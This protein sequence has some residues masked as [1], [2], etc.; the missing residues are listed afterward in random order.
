LMDITS[1]PQLLIP[2]RTSGAPQRRTLEL[3]SL[4]APEGRDLLPAPSGGCACR[5]DEGGSRLPPLSAPGPV[6]RAA[7]QRHPHRA[8]PAGPTLGSPASLLL[9]CRYDS[10]FGELSSSATPTPNPSTGTEQAVQVFTNL[11]DSMNRSITS[12]GMGGIRPRTGSRERM[13]Q[14]WGEAPRALP[15]E[16]GGPRRASRAFRLA[17]PAERE[18]PERQTERSALASPAERKREAPPG[19]GGKAFPH[20][21]PAPPKEEPFDRGIWETRGGSPRQS[22]SV[23]R[24]P[25][26]P[27]AEERKKRGGPKPAPLGAAERNLT[28]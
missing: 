17:P 12:Q 8:C 27:R 13:R 14:G 10:S 20:V 26:S 28:A 19:S 2:F 9:T 4:P 15:V 11:T 22:P 1:P 3:S 24:G 5:H 23:L 7:P 18:R 6:G 25:A 21:R 16:R